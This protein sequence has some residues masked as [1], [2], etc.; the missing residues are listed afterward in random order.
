MSSPHVVHAEHKPAK[1]LVPLLLGATIAALAASP[2]VQSNALLVQ[3]FWAAGSLLGAWSLLLLALP[4]LRASAGGI[5][6]TLRA[7]HYIQAACQ[8]AVY[9]YWGWYWQP[10]Y[11]MAVL[12]GAQL[13]FAYGFSM[14]LS[15]SRGHVY[16]MGFG[17]IPIILSINLFLWFRDDWFYLQFLMIAVGFLGKEFVRWQRDGRSVHIFNP[18]AFALGLFSLVLIASGSTGLTWGQEIASTLTLAPR[19]YLFLFLVGLV[20]M[21]FFEI[22]LVAGTAA[23]VLFGLSAVSSGITGVPYFID[24]EIPAAVFLGLHLLIT[25]PSTSP[26]TPVGKTMFGALYGFGVFG[27]YALLG[28]MGTPTFYDKLLCVPLLNLSV[29]AID[30][31]VRSRNW[32]EAWT[33]PTEIAVRPVW[34]SPNLNLIRMGAWILFFGVMA[35]SGRTDSR[36]TGDALPFWEEACAQSRGNACDRLIQLEASYCGDNAAWACNELGLHYRE[37]AI[38][39]ADAQLGRSYLARACELRFQPGCMNLLEPTR[40]VRIEPRP[41]DLR[42]ML[43][44][45]GLNLMDSEIP[46]LLERACAHDWS[47]ACQ[48]IASST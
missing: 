32:T 37:G 48:R 39:A 46:D 4:Q 2:R 30:A 47:F 40:S 24:S 28:A 26:R 10:V 6:T 43:R 27:L 33:A 12:L 14:L 41:L 18:S 16:S 1:L 7:Q 36:H 38:V 11:D 45:G 29:R 42:L 25:D 31:V 13:L 5:D 15:W 8:L 21:Y 9:A 20:V 17:P 19:I 35:V 44:E 34:V 3:S 23:A 22:T